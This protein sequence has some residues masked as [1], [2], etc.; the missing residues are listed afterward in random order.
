MKLS[1]IL[2]AAVLLTLACEIGGQTPAATSS[3]DLET[4]V[5]A[6]VA[7]AL[8][9]EIP[10]PTPDIEG[11]VR[12]RVEATAAAISTITPIP[13]ATPTLSPTSTPTPDL[14]SLISAVMTATFGHS[15]SEPP[16]HSDSA[17]NSDGSHPNADFHSHSHADSGPACH[18]RRARNS[19]GPDPYAHRHAAIYPVPCGK[20]SAG[21]RAEYS[22][23]ACQAR[24][25]HH[26]D[27]HT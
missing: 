19:D 22:A 3:P 24:R 20:S 4:T 17:R 11:T 1:T 9:T 7:A 21:T 10:A 13:T 6:M 23:S 18:G 14:S 2:L 26:H 12:A 25:N 8:P 27:G 16:R 15:D 5:Q